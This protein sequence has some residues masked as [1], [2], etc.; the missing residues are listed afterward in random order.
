VSHLVYLIGAPGVGKSTLAG[1]LTKRCRRWPPPRHD[2]LS[3]AAGDDV[4]AAELGG[5]RPGFSGTDVLPMNASPAACTWVRSRAVRLPLLLAEGDRLAHAGF[6]E[7]AALGGYQVIVVYLITDEAE[8][9]RRHA[10]RGARQDAIWRRG[11]ATKSARLARHAHDHHRLIVLDAG[12]PP[13]DEAA[14]L[15]AALPE[16][17]VLP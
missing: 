2:L 15:R 14:E 12:P 10:A 8:I 7:A 17:E 5:R 16:L 6:L 13:A 11:R 1:E 9:E 3:P 4:I